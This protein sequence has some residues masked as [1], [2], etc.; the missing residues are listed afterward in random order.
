VAILPGAHERT[1]SETVLEPADT[2][3]VFS[4]GITESE[5]GGTQYG[6]GPMQRFLERPP[7]SSEALVR[8]LLDDVGKF[9][10][11]SSPEDDLTLLAVRRR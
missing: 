3:L 8:G 6:E 7:D 11:A 4:D 2:L 1:V 9:R 5:R 10:G